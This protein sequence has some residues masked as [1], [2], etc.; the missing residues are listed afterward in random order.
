MPKRNL[1]LGLD[2]GTESVRALLVEVKTGEELGTAV[3]NYPHGVLE[4]ELPDGTRL[5]PDTALQDPRDYLVALERVL[6]QA[7]QQA[8]L[9]ADEVI[10]I[11]VDF[12]SST[13]LPTLADG[14]PLCTQQ[15]FQSEPYAW[16]KLWKD[17]AAQAEAEEINTLAQRLINPSL[18]G[19][20]RRYG[21]R[22]SSEWLIPKS[23][24]MLRRAPGV[25]R[26]AA[27]IIE[28]GDW[29]VCQLTGRECR[30]SCQAGY[31]A[32][33]DRAE[34]YPPPA[35]FAALHPE[36]ANVVAEKL[37]T[38]IHP[39]GTVAGGLTTI[40]A[41]KLGLNPGTP[42]GVAIID[43]HAAVLGSSVAEA[44]KMVLVMGTSTCHMVMSPHKIFATGI[45]GIVED[46]IVPG[47][48]AYESG[49]SA[50]GDIFS[51]FVKNQLPAE[52]HLA[53]EEEG[54]GVF[55]Y[56][57]RA[58]AKLRPGE[59]GLLALDWWNGNRSI[60]M[61]A[62]LS[63]LV[64]GMTL[65]TLPEEIY[66]ALIEATAFGT[67]IIIDNHTSQGIAVDE[68]Y[69]CG[70]LAERN[71][72]LLQ[73]YA[74]VTNRPL[75]VAAS[76]QATAL[77]AAILGAIAAGKSRGGYDSFVEA[78]HTM[79]RLKERIFAPEAAAVSIYAS[80]FAEYQRLH[81]FFGKGEIRTMRALRE[82]RPA[83]NKFK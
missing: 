26:A 59:S 66:R 32:L 83:E 22:V 13:V 79:A 49:Q 75:R 53:A 14:T 47:L 18:S 64:I 54:L 31:K 45:A 38:Q 5:E 34:G 82:I 36:F 27:R 68:L 76:S 7:M 57:E 58:A 25:Y 37:S 62:L 81:N 28:A 24:C 43:A 63:G 29:L 56:L 48:V 8:N 60:L 65:A 21:G 41:Q 1:A 44:G 4:R 67:R 30:S 19:F 2:F 10:G 17:H 6:P 3:E 72:L 77:G 11:G 23:L 15:E 42:V 35:F 33:W 74:D 78:T 80:L 70:G 9:T 52:Y 20:I 51:W 73:I 55:Q 39:L 16:V 40:W 61:D 71:E 50:V 46:G 12:T 69:A